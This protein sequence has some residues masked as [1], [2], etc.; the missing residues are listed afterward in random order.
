METVYTFDISRPLTFNYTGQLITPSSEWKHERLALIDYQLILVS[1]GTLYISYQKQN[2]IVPHGEYLL[3][4]P[5][6]APDNYRE[7]FHPSNCCFY[8][9]HFEADHEIRRRTED[10]HSGPEPDPHILKLPAQA[11]VPDMDKMLVLLQQ[12]QDCVRSG[13]PKTASSYMATTILCEL[14]HQLYRDQAD[15]SL[16]KAGDSR[17]Q[18]YYNILDYIQRN[19]SRN[20]RVYDIARHF[21]YHEKYLSH[22]FHTLSGMTLKQYILKKKI[23]TANYLLTDTNQTVADIAAF[24]GYSDS[25]N[26]MKLYKKET[27]LTPTEYRNAFVKRMISH[28]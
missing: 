10:V 27:G 28:Y 25:H 21:G 4:P 8:W 18:I 20:L 22:M 11:S 16:A 5:A 26:F 1:G 9:I 7:G 3:L 24:L 14:N 23:E 17:K 15:E 19:I 13:Y 2:Y 12:L 6:A